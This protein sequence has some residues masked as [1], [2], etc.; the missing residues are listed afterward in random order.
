MKENH[1]R[2]GNCLLNI[3][4]YKLRVGKHLAYYIIG[5]GVEGY[6]VSGAKQVLDQVLMIPR[7]RHVWKTMGK[8]LK[9]G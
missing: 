2:R 1:L 4:Y 6:I 9:I 3:T 8:K 5:Q 7:V